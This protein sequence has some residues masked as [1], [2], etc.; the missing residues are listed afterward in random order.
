MEYILH[1]NVHGP[2]SRQYSTVSRVQLRIVR[3]VYTHSGMYMWHTRVK[4]TNERKKRKKNLRGILV[5]GGDNVCGMY[6][7]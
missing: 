5:L 1:P 6:V 4:Q 2:D 3:T 7:R